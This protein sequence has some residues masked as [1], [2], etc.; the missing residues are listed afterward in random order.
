[1]IFVR[2]GLSV[3]AYEGVRA[4]IPDDGTTADMTKRSEAVLTARDIRGTTI[5]ATPKDVTTA[6]RGTQ[7]SVRVTATCDANSLMP[8]WFFGGRSLEATATMVKE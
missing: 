1:M 5:T 7:V 3:A 6:A 2:Q 4:A 8:A